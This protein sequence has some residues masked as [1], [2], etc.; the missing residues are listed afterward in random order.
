MK[1]A[2]HGHERMRLPRWVRLW[3]YFGGALCATSGAA[4]LLLHYFAQREGEF[5]V[6]PH[7]FEHATLVTH[8]V[9]GLA[10]LWVFGLIWLAHVRRGWSKPQHRW[11]G[12]TMA[13]LMLWLALS[14][15]GLYYLGDEAWRGFV[16]IAHWSLGLFATVWLPMHIWL[17]RRAIQRRHGT[18]H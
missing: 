9:A 18:R 8:G 5:G 6:E 7:P 2:G 11:A 13:A 3:V 14:A 12:G 1:P 15:A 10:M 17:G 4:W 16:G